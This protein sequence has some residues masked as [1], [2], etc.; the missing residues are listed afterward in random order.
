[1]LKLENGD[2]YRGTF[3]NDQRSGTGYCRFKSG[4]LFKG[5]WKDD[6]PHGNGTLY[7]GKNEIIDCRFEKGAISDRHQVKILLSD[8]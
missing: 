6:K 3:K 2:V 4:A 1:M 8:G 5:E 7:S